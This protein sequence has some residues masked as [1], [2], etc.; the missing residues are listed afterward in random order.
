M[1]VCARAHL[2]S[3]CSSLCLLVHAVTTRGDLLLDLSGLCPPT[4]RAHREHAD[5]KAGAPERHTKKVLVLNTRQGTE[6]LQVESVTVYS[7][8]RTQESNNI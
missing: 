2:L 3:F 6:M 4:V 1:C 8:A 5:T 7:Q